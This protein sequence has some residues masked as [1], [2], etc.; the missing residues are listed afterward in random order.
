MLIDQFD[1]DLPKKLIAQKPVSPRDYARMLVYNRDKQELEF[2]HFFDLPNYLGENDVLVF[3]NSKV[4][5]AR[6]V[7]R[8]DNKELE[9]FLLEKVDG[10]W[11]ALIRPGKVFTVGQKVVFENV[12]FEVM[13]IDD[14]GF[15]YLKIALNDQELQEFLVKYGQMPIPPYIGGNKYEEADYNT[16]YSARLGSVAA[17]TAGLHFTDQL[18]ARLRAKGVQIEFVTLHVGLGTFLPVKVRDTKFHKMHREKYEIGF[19]T[20][21][22]LN[23]SIKEGKRIIAVGTTSVRVLEDNFGRYGGIIPGSFET[24]ILIEPGYKWKVIRALITNFHLPKSTLLL[25]VSAFMGKEKALEL[26]E[27]AVIRG[28]KFFSFGDGMLIL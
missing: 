17:P 2:G 24:N 5:P 26:Y 13:A 20:A 25:L 9:I 14:N 22:N 27:K 21:K 7:F 18:L 4:I 19:Q 23:K 3:N 28:L 10:L 15:R 1:F 12:E 6:L 16:V 11:K 8:R